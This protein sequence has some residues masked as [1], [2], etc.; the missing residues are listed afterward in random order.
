MTSLYPSL[1][2]VS[3]ISVAESG[4]VSLPFS[5]TSRVDYLSPLSHNAYLNI[6]SK[7]I[8]ICYADVKYERRVR[9]SNK[10]WIRLFWKIIINK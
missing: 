7:Y 3:F 10:K 9:Q 1:P 5:D 6:F 4:F 8:I 2:S